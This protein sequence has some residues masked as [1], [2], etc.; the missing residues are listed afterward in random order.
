MKDKLLKTFVDEN[1]EQRYSNLYYSF[2]VNEALRGI[3]SAILNRKEDMYVYPNQHPHI[4]QMMS[5]L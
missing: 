5:S 3:Y 2:S 4:T 1:N